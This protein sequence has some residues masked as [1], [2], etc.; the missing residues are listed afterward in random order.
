[1]GAITILENHLITRI[2]RMKLLFAKIAYVKRLVI[3]LETIYKECV[4]G[5]GLIFNIFNIQLLSAPS[6]NI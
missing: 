3:A 4:A 5:D 2:T 1:M 6:T